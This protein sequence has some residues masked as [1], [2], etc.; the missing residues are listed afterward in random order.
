MIGGMWEKTQQNCQINVLSGIIYTLFTPTMRTQTLLQYCFLLYIL[1][2][3]ACSAPEQP[4]S[5]AEATAVADSLIQ[6]V[7]QRESGWSKGLLDF[8]ELQKKVLAHDDKLNRTL[9]KGAMNGFKNGELGQQI[10]RSL[11]KTGTYELVKQYE[12]NNRQ[13]LVFRMYTEQEQLNY[14]DMELIKREDKIK[15]ADIFIYTTGE[16]LSST[17]AQ[18]LESMNDQPSAVSKLRKKDLQRIELIKSY[19]NQNNFEKADKEFKTL[20]AGIR[21]QKIYKIVYIKIASGL[22]TDEYLAALN[23]FQQQY[24]DAPNMYLLM[25]DAYFLKKD[26]AG[27]L[28]C[29]NSLDS[30]INKD[31]FLD[32]YRGLLYKQSEDRA[33]SLMCLERLHQNL[34]RF[35]PGSLQ[36]IDAYLE[37]KQ[38]DK[39]V[40]L[41]QTYRTSKDADTQ[42]LE[43]LYLLY[44]DYKKKMETVG[45]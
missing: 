35:G 41:T 44:P 26:Y 30:L 28:R 22:G 27:A 9:V 37:N 36:L 23:K 1:F 11:G 45:E 32:Y 20:P 38:L 40:A 10:I 7:A 17:L 19:I 13:H 39:A 25:I 18:S 31:P 33:N 34:P 8:E 15:V 6:L 5:K 2:V 29:V 12:K 3:T 24:P 14:H 42:T 43:S 4:V 21:R 16:D